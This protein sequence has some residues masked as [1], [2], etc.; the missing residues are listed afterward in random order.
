MRVLFFGKL[1]DLAGQREYQLARPE[2]V[3]T[4]A[5]LSRY[6]GGEFE[7]LTGELDKSSVRYVVNEE[8]CPATMAVSEDDEV[9][10]LPP[11]SGG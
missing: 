10:F 3:A 8:I 7:R 9:A 11:V 4:V 5:D 1:A 2:S 6:L